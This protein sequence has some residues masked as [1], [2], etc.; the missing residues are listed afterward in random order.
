LANAAIAVLERARALGD[1]DYVFPGDRPG[2]PLSN[3]R[4]LK[5]VRRI[6]AGDVTIHG[7]RAVFKT[8]ASEQTG[9]AHEVVEAAL[10][11]AIPDA[12]ERAYRRTDLFE[13]RR[14]LM[15]SWA[16]YCAKPAST[17]ATVVPMRE[18]A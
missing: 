13:K 4:L 5:L 7:F 6:A 12:V 17:G 11:H 16:D 14:K 1:G 10:A 8:W 18:M 3:P 9:F 15:Q 2:R